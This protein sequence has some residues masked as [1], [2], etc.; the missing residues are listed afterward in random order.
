MQKVLQ[1]E[2]KTLQ[3]NEKFLVFSI[4][5]MMKKYWNEK[6]V[7]FS[8]EDFACNRT[9]TYFRTY[10]QYLPIVGTSEAYFV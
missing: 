7:F 2:E 4:T 3:E 1:N 10:F 9:I 8:E 5:E 6:P